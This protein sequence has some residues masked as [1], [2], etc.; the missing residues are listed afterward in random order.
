MYDIENNNN[1]VIEVSFYALLEEGRAVLPV[2]A[3]EAAVLVS[4]LLYLSG[5]R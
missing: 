1:G 3:L 5:Q 4:M 2:D